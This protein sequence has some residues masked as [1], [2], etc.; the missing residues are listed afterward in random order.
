MKADLVPTPAHPVPLPAPKPTI[1]R[2]R[3][4][5]SGESSSKLPALVW[6]LL[7]AIIGG[8]WLLVFHRYRRWTVW[9]AGA[10]PFAVVLFVFYVYV[11]RLLPTNY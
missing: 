3:T 11:E 4:G 8:L 7:A 2:T 1:A 9:F 5:L 10:I 6:G